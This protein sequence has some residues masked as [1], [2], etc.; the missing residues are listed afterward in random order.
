VAGAAGLAQQLADVVQGTA[1]PAIGASTGSAIP[2]VVASSAGGKF[3]PEDDPTSGSASEGYW[4]G[5]TIVRLE[6]DGAVVVEQR[7]VF[8]YV[9][10]QAISHELQPGQH[11][12]L[13][14][15]GREPSGVST[16]TATPTLETTQYDQIDS[17]AITH[18]Y[19]LV[20]AD[21]GAPYL[22]ETDARGNYVPLDP[23]VAT[24]NEQT[25]YIQTGSGSHPRVYAIALLSVGGQE[26]T[27]P[28]VFEP[29]KGYTPS[30]PVLPPLPSIS[31]PAPL[32]PVHAAAAG[33]PAPPLPS[34]PPPAPPEVGSPSLPQLPSLTPPPPVAA[35][36]PPA[37]PAPPPA[38]PPPGQPTPLPLALQARLAPIGIQA[39]VVP[40]SPPP[41]NPA[42]PS[43]SAARKEAKQRQ[44]A[45]AKSE[46]GSQERAQDATGDLTSAGP[47]PPGGMA[48]SRRAAGDANHP[49]TALRSLSQVSA[50][51]SDLLYGG[52]LGIAA[53]VLA[54]GWSVV[55]PAARRRQPGTPAP[56]WHRN[57]SR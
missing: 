13:D 22:P 35:V 42:P 41:V 44:A 2:F 11:L 47:G 36:V 48:M 17:P 30:R 15:Y 34:S 49:F 51:P 20:Q 10:I 46:E 57:R 9:T 3:G 50:W 27:W 7:P 18:R 40:P 4:H 45:T 26:T 55:P 12:Q 29:S 43:G 25:G 56:A 5:Y 16:A 31:P 54:L 33:T 21:P 38:P 28:V 23:S 8:D 6:R 52:G 19:D 1:A 24:V 39:T 53:L 32:P 37:P 14:G